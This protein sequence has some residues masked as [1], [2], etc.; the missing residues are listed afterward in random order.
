[1]ELSSRDALDRVVRRY[2]AAAA[3][4]DDPMLTH[5]LGTS[6][7]G[8]GQ[9]SELRATFDSQESMLDREAAFQGGE[10]GRQAIMRRRSSA[11]SRSMPPEE[12]TQNRAKRVLFEATPTGEAGPSAFERVEVGEVKAQQ[13]S[14]SL[15]LEG[16]KSK[17][18][19]GGIRGR[20]THIT[21][22]GNPVPGTAIELAVP[23]KASMAQVIEFV[24]NAYMKRDNCESLHLDGID[25]EL[26][27][28]RASRRGGG[29]PAGA[30]RGGVAR[31]GARQGRAG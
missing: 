14:L 17:G 31:E 13:S 9:R 1:M 20:T 29:G 18:G 27:M 4:H 15:Q 24:L 5:M 25:F 12:V 26:L 2:V 6:P 8:N 28:V 11:S 30:L 16:P 19:A 7:E 23:E 22:Y 3:Q 10:A 21:V